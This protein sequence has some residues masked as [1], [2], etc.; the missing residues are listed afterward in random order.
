MG[1]R[2]QFWGILGMFLLF[3]LALLLQDFSPRVWYLA[4]MSSE[5]PAGS[6]LAGLLS[7]SNRTTAIVDSYQT[8]FGRRPNSGELSYWTSVNDGRMQSL[9]SLVNNHRQWLRSS[10]EEREATVRRAFQTVFGHGVSQGQQ[11]WYQGI[12]NDV[13]ARGTTYVELRET[14]ANAFVDS[15]YSQLLQRT[16]E[17]SGRRGWANNILYGGWSTER[18]WTAIAQSDERLV[19][20]GTWAPA[21]VGYDSAHEICFGAIGPKC[22]GAPRSNPVWKDKFTRPDGME[23]GYIEIQVSVGSILHDN[24]CLRSG[25][26]GTFCNGLA[27]GILLDS[28]PLATYVQAAS[29]EWNKAAYNTYDGRFWT[30]RFGPYPVNGQER[31]NWSDDLTKVSNRP[32]K[33]AP[34][35][36]G[37]LQTVGLGGWPVPT[38]DYKLGESRQ[39]KVLK[40]P[41]GTAVDRGDAAF[42]AA[43]QYTEE[44]MWWVAKWWGTCK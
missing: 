31:A 43:Q 8:A 12:V 23:M 37:G 38:I 16:A 21:Q 15:A 19:R 44:G 10:A 1:R 13:A 14:L 22:D 7:G 25:G 24:A 42:C 35:L 33:M 36:A 9:Q 32:S 34:V 6:S 28:L 3:T 41:R 11:S 30:A 40:A 2:I 27:K 18:V 17:A 5:G 39:S 29:L 20:F 4:N 26:V